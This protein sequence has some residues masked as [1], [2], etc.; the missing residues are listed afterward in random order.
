VCAHSL[1][2]WALESNPNTAE[3][4][5]LKAVEGVVPKEDRKEGGREEN[6]CVFEI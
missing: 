5:K 3:T 4:S 1:V 2:L 6:I